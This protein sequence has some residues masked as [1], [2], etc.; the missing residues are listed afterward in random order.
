MTEEQLKFDVVIVGGGV[1]GLSAAIKL[2]DA[3]FEVLVIERGNYCGAKN[4]MG[5]VIYRQPTEE[6]VPDFFKEAPIQRNIV[7]T[8]IWLLTDKANTSFTYKNPDL[9]SNSYT[10]FRAEFDQ[11]LAGKA[12]E[13]GVT[14]LTDVTVTDVLR[15][16]ADKIVGVKT[17]APDG[18]VYSDVVIAADGVN[19]LLSKKLGLHKEIKA[20]KVALAVK[21][22]IS[23]P[24]NVIE[25]RFNL[26]ENEGATIEFMGKVSKGMTGIGFLYTNKDSISL[27]IGC[28]VS[29]YAKFKVNPSDLLEEIKQHP[30]FAPLIKDGVL[31][32]YMAHL[33]PEGGYNEI[34][35]LSADNFLV[36][37]D[38]AM[39]VNGIHREGSNLAMTSGRL[40]AEAVIYAREKKDYSN[41]TLSR[42]RELFNKSF[43]AKDLKKYKDTMGF[44]EHNRQFFNIYPEILSDASNEMLTVDSLPKRAKEWKILRKIFAQRTLF[45]IIRDLIGLARR[46]V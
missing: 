2:A 18:D 11:W 17:D 1:A 3:K 29:D 36:I 5:G 8:R 31:K 44:I 28:L 14:I 38:A 27:G 40:A 26:R 15:D 35:P 7:E 32:E 33:I 34:P 46:L 41:K 45:G 37:G 20:D 42:Y 21:E 23:L 6:I 16:S 4:V 43:I 9:N 22:V 39:L 10:V 13:K 30:S 19:S 25:E 24:K 12:E